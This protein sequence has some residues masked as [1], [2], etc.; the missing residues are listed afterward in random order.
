MPA[1]Q[2]RLEPSDVEKLQAVVE[3]LSELI[4]R[5]GGGGEI[6]VLFELELNQELAQ[7][8]LIEHGLWLVR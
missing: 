7:E 3:E 2:R 4:D 1:Y 8:A 6:R 5:E